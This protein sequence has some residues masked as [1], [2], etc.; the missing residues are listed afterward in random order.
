M[1][2]SDPQAN[3]VFS[4]LISY[5]PRVG[6]TGR[7]RTA[8]EDYCTESL[9]WCLRNSEDFQRKFLDLVK[10]ELL[11]SRGN[12][13]LFAE[14]E[15]KL[16]I[17]TQIVFGT[18]PQKETGEDAEE[19]R[20]RFDL[21]IR[22]KSDDFVLVLEDKV[23][24]DF[25]KNQL[26]DYRNELNTGRSFPNHNRKV[27]VTLTKWRPFDKHDDE[28]PDA[29]VVWSDVQRILA[30][31]S[32]RK[33]DR[34][35]DLSPTDFILRQFAEFLQFRGMYFMNIPTIT[36]N[37]SFED[38][39]SFCH[40][41][42]RILLEVSADVPN[43]DIRG[44]VQLHEDNGG[45]ELWIQIGGDRFCLAFK[46]KPELELYVQAYCE[47][48]PPNDPKLPRNMRY[49]FR[50]KCFEIRGNFEGMNGKADAIRDWFI[51]AA[52]LAIQLRDN[53]LTRG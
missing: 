47:K 2:S 48:K 5:T 26:R 17:E 43:A 44:N 8:L 35:K 49:V 14:L 24:S 51:N 50:Q 20:G 6:K 18:N 16:E 36:Q 30:N 32:E 46:V 33:A 27:L 4:R 12:E 13:A 53:G 23:D 38:A 7:A 22:S 11:C 28:K 31:V 25:R 42:Q 10:D 41:I 9:A 37:Q 34:E 29:L 21:V 19:P 39:I 45:K 52:R 1:H 40:S 15:E 3:N